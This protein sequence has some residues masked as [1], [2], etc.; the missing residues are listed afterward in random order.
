MFR[1]YSRLAMLA[2]ITAL[3]TLLIISCGGGGGDSAPVRVLQPIS[4]TGNTA[5]VVI[6]LTNTPTLVTNVLFG[7]STASDI[8][9]AVTITE[10]N[11]LPGE[12]LSSA[13]RYMDVFDFSLDNIIG[14]ATHGFK[15]PAGVDI[16]KTEYCE[17]GYYTVEGS[18]N[19]ITATGTLTFDYY[20]CLDDGVTLDGMMHFHVHYMD[21]YNMSST[22][23]FVLMTLSCQEFN[24]SLS[25]TVLMDDSISGNS[26]IE[27]STNNYVEKDNNTDRVYQYE[28]YVMTVVTNDVYSYYSG[29]SITYSGAPVAIMYDSMLGSLTV[30]SITPF[31]FSSTS[32][33]YPDLGGQLVLTGNQ[34]SIQL[35]VESSRHVKLELDLDGALGYEV[36]RY[37]LW[38]EL[39]N[40]TTLNLADSDS[41]GMHDSWEDSFGLDPTID[42]A[43]DN[44][45]NDTL[46][47][48]EE[49]EQGYDPNNPLSQ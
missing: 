40:H 4:Y 14:N 38:S 28:N 6:T 2:L 37:V 1:K 26:L 31:L 13:D 15:I 35:S 46:T 42:D 11:A 22:M 30:E 45:D 5:P 49:Y 34:T 27:Q 9:S 43:A 17:S 18:L 41:D 47:N 24:A 36:V 20:N 7:G 44:L 21:Y 3:S 19:D 10:T 23:E 39:D 29:G 33:S 25:G 8:P 16:N 12:F 48:L 32:R